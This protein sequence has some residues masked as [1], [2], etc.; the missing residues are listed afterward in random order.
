VTAPVTLI[1]LVFDEPLEAAVAGMVI[2]IAGTALLWIPAIERGVARVLA[3]SREPDDAERARLEPMLRRIGERAGLRTDKLVLRVQEDHEMNASAGAVHHL[4]VTTGALRRD[5]AELEAALAHE[6]GHHR[7]LHPASTALVWWLSLP[8]IA[9]AAVYKGLRAVAGRLTGRVR[10]LAF[11]VRVAIVI[12]QVSVMWMYFLAQLLAMRA[13]R[14]SEYV[15]DAAA[16]RWGYGQGLAD[17]LASDGPSPRGNLI[18][19]LTDEHPPTELRVERLRNA[20]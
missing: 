1:G 3:P 7:G 14:V 8:G 19:R 13:A 12:W 4:F 2:A 18:E 10:P 16:A 11:V 17:L 20:R 5:D 6:L 9:L 15:A